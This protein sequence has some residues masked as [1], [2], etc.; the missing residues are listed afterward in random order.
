M[1]ESVVVIDL[2]WSIFNILSDE[3]SF[4]I[5]DSQE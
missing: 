4:K 3:T 5:F 1:D 2:N